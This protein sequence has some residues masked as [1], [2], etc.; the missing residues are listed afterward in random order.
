MWMIAF[1]LSM[2]LASAT[3]A[4][5]DCVGV[6][7]PPTVVLCSDPELTQLADERQAAINE[8]RA[9]IGEKA[10]PGSMSSTRTPASS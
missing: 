9:R 7:F 2:V 5:F 10:W 1:W 8:A 3:A 6:T 4:A